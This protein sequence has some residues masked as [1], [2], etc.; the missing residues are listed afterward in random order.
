VI[1]RAF[2]NNR[3]NGTIALA[4]ALAVVA[5]QFQNTVLER[6]WANGQGGTHLIVVLGAIVVMW[7]L[8]DRDFDTLGLRTRVEPSWRFWAVAAAL[9]GLAVGLAGAGY[10]LATGA[11]QRLSF[12]APDADTW[13]ARVPDACIYAPVFEELVFRVALC[14]ALVP[15]I[16]RW[17]TVIVSGAIF[18][19]VHITNGVAG[20]DNFIAG[21]FLAWAYLRSESLTVPIA[22]HA[23]GNLIIVLLAPST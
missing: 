1:G 18:G 19:L 20:P 17:P 12:N 22:L 5:L 2:R 8:A 11:Y 21:Y 4:V 13:L 16:G 3:K 23:A 15:W 7:R 6:P 14:A 9:I 10:L